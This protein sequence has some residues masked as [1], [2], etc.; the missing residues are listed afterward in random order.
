MLT[1][2]NSGRM[3]EKTL[4]MGD[5]L[6][7][8]DFCFSCGN[9]TEGSSYCSAECRESDYRQAP[10]SPEFSPYLSPVPPLVSSAKSAC[11]TPPSS[12]TNSPLHSSHPDLADP[13][14]LDLPPPKDGYNYS[15]S[16][17]ANAAKLAST[18]SINY[19]PEP[20]ASPLVAAIDSVNPNKDLSYRRKIDRPHPT[21]PSPLYFRQKA[22]AVH[23]SPALNPISPSAPLSRNPFSLDSPGAH[24]HDDDITLLSLPRRQA[25]AVPTPPVIP[26]PSHCGRP[27]C[28]GV[29]KK[30]K[31]DTNLEKKPRRKSWQPSPP[32]PVSG[33]TPV[34][35]ASNEEVLVSP[36]I[37]NLRTG[38]SASDEGPP[39]TKTLRREEGRESDG[40]S[41]GDDAHSAFACYL[42][43]HLADPAAPASSEPRGRTVE[44]QDEEMKR[45][46]SVDATVVARQ[47]VGSSTPVPFPSTPG[48]PTRTLFRRGP[49]AQVQSDSAIERLTPLD[50]ERS[51]SASLDNTSSREDED[52]SATLTIPSQLR[53]R[54]RDDTIRASALPKSL[55]TRQRPSLLPGH[56]IQATTDSPSSSC[57]VS[58]F[59][60]PPATPPTVGRNR[61][62]SSRRRSLSPEADSEDEDR[63]SRTS[64]RSR[65]SRVSRSRGRGSREEETPRVRGRTRER[66]VAEEEEE[67]EEDRGRG[68][69]AS[70]RTQSKS[71]SRS[72]R[73]RG[74]REVVIS[75]GAYGHVDSGDSDL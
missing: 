11:S 39:T 6:P 57:A 71:K 36:R 27:G 25:D 48:R 33:F 67:V 54:Q 64:S 17:P 43:S 41:S 55:T 4:E 66:V 5:E 59:P 8:G 61:S 1:A 29:P 13:P 42:F 62:S 38:R 30:L 16:L 40:D 73:G 7:F 15:H 26:T 10:T 28:I 49:A 65:S 63:R 70:S 50:S 31:V 46:R 12:A 51:A 19:Q 9:A 53:G 69:R 20:L 37:R 21:V 75:G 52:Q 34:D 56:F 72:S 74:G 14:A 3:R 47:S 2:V 58:P 23:S 68:R 22:A 60:S 24:I 35:N 44:S 32:Q 18:W 45:S